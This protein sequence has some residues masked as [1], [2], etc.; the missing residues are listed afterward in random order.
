VLEIDC[1]DGNKY[2]AKIESIFNPL[3]LARPE[4]E[5]AKFA[6]EMQQTEDQKGGGNPLFIRKDAV[7]WTCDQLRDKAFRKSKL[8][9]SEVVDASRLQ[10]S[11]TTGTWLDQVDLIP[12]TAPPEGENFSNLIEKA[13]R[14]AIPLE[15]LIEEADNTAEVNGRVGEYFSDVA[16][17]NDA[18]LLE[19]LRN[20]GTNDD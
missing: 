2:F 16:T 15:R 14:V 11:E 6:I 10:H 3:G 18:A 17:S 4:F 19:E 13:Y 5:S 8:D 9:N 7:L 12:E 20:L 1:K